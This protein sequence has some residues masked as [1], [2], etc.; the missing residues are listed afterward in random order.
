M[1]SPAP[2]RRRPGN[3]GSACA[4]APEP[5]PR[6]SLEPVEPGR[7]F[8]PPPVGDAFGAVETVFYPVEA[9]VVGLTIDVAF[10]PVDAV[11]DPVDPV[12]GPCHGVGCDER[13]SEGDGARGEKNPRSLFL[14][15]S[16]FHVHSFYD[17]PTRRSGFRSQT[18]YGSTNGADGGVGMG[19]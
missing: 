13:Q 12:A 18:A 15:P 6:P 3:G 14:S 1:D 17:W 2:G 16:R 9:T 7:E 5:P 8:A 4:A 11:L 19:Q 10:P